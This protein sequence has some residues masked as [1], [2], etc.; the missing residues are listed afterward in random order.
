MC[1]RRLRAEDAQQDEDS[2]HI[3]RDS[4]V[5]YELNLAR[6][7]PF[8]ISHLVKQTVLCFGHTFSRVAVN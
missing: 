3:G 6:V 5:I 7:G 8:P 2:C 4:E 1:E